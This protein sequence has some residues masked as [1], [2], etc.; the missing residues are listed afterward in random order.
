MGGEDV[1]TDAEYALLKQ[2][3]ID[4]DILYV[5][6][7]TIDSSNKIKLALNT[8]WSEHYYKE[9]LTKI[10]TGRYDIVH[11]QNF[12]PLFSPSIFYAAKKAGA[13]VIM[14]VRNYRLV[15]PNALMYINNKICND[16][17]GKKIPFPAVFKKCYRDSYSANG[18]TVAM[19]G[20]H[21]LLNTWNT[22]IDG[23]V[24]IS[25]FVKKQLLQVSFDEEKL[26]VKYNFVSSALPFNNNPD[27]YYIYVGRLS[28]EK[29]L[30]ILLDTFKKN[31]KKLFVLGDGPLRQDVRDATEESP[32]ISFLGKLSISQ[33][34]N[35]IS[36]AKALIFP[37]KWHEPFGRTIVE[38]FAHGTPVIGASLGGV[39]EL[40]KDGYNGFLFDPYI[41]NG[42]SEAIARFDNIANSIEIR[43]N[44]YDS[45]KDKF[46]PS[47]N[48]TQL[49]NIYN[50]VLATK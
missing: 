21:N 40:I 2:H 43:Q 3:G 31:K 46:D 35:M 30:D 18:V 28:V 48:F 6:N 5:D 29:G 26:Y 41:N 13:K 23:F 50:N 8:I 39:T 22:K 38:S 10:K 37:S 4:I 19:L 1:S 14:S 27:D 12:F 36:N 45:Y 9:L 33:T 32:N 20:L 34:Y 47:S 24:C 15:C 17:V 7:N 25:E 11:V 42:L 49:L 16:C 44:A